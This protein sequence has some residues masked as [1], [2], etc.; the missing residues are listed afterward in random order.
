[1]DCNACRYLPGPSQLM[2]TVAA[3]VLRGTGGDSRHLGTLGNTAP[4]GHISPDKVVEVADE[5]HI[6]R[7]VC[8]SRVTSASASHLVTIGETLQQHRK[9]LLALRSARRY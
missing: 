6:L 5:Y 3:N 9:L 1:M 4:L 8:P 7:G 2:L